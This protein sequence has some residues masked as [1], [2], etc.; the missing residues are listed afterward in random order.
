MEGVWDWDIAKGTEY[1]SPRGQ[2]IFVSRAHD[3]ESPLEA[4]AARLHPVD[5]ARLRSRMAE[6]MDG[7]LTRL[8]MTLRIRQPEGE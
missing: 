2:G 4:V 8:R 7:R 5:A 1:R 6:L 3:G